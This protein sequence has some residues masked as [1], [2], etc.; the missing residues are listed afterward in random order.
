MPVDQVFDVLLELLVVH[1]GKEIP[2]S[3]P[4]LTLLFS[5]PA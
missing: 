4:D 5:N 2:R 1:G 3:V